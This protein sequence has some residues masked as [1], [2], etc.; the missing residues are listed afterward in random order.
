MHGE[1]SYAYVSWY[2]YTGKTYL[3]TVFAHE[4]VVL[5]DEET[6]NLGPIDRHVGRS[7]LV[8]PITATLRHY[9]EKTASSALPLSW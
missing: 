1:P 5:D 4:I 3:P 8:V 7:V 9:F 2:A 6:E